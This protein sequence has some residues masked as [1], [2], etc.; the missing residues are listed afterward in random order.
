LDTGPHLTRY[1]AGGGGGGVE[2]APSIP[3]GLVVMEPAELVEVVKL[4]QEQLLEEMEQPEQQI[5]VVVQAV[6]QD[7]M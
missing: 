6:L 5:Q 2:S 1:F 4:D 3:G 7:M